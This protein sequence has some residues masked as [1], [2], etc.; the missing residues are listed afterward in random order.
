MR[1]LPGERPF[2]YYYRPFLLW[3]KFSNYYILIKNKTEDY[4]KP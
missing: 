2:F 3:H 1:N 4:N